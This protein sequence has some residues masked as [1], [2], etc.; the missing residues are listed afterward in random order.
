MF[1]SIRV[2][3]SLLK[4]YIPEMSHSIENFF[5]FKKEE[6]DL[7]TFRKHLEEKTTPIFRFDYQSKKSITYMKIK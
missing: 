7:F 2:L 1:E 6:L 4:I 3:N 5:T